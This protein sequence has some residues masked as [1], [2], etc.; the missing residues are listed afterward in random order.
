MSKKMK[1]AYR[2][3]RMR[4]RADAAMA[5]LPAAILETG[6]FLAGWL[7]LGGAPVVGLYVMAGLAAV[8]LA[9]VAVF[10]AATGLMRLLGY[11]EVALERWSLA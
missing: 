1:I 11:T 9:L 4:D 5:K 6:L 8:S 10:L 7:L 2:A 3:L